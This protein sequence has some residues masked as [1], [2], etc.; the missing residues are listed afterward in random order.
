MAKQRFTNVV[1]ERRA[2]V[3]LRL[4][5]KFPR[6]FKRTSN[7]YNPKAFRG[8]EEA[9]RVMKLS[10]DGS[11]TDLVGFKKLFSFYCDVDE[12]TAMKSNVTPWMPSRNSNSGES[13]FPSKNVIV[14]HPNNA[15]E[16]AREQSCDDEESV[17]FDFGDDY[18]NRREFVELG[19]EVEFGSAWCLRVSRRAFKDSKYRMNDI[20]KLS[21]QEEMLKEFGRNYLF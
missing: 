3:L 7:A 16:I 6:L 13:L 8:M 4:Y 14:N 1:E 5:N 18:G 15:E 12:E 17:R 20:Y 10:D 19:K 11:S 2:L 9:F 21:S